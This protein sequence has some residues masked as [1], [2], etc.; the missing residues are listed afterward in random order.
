MTVLIPK[1]LLEKNGSVSFVYTAL[2][3][4]RPVYGVPYIT[5][6]KIVCKF[7]YGNCNNNNLIKVTTALKN[8][9]DD[10]LIIAKTF[11]NGFYEIDVT[12]FSIENKLF[13]AV[14]SD[15]IMKIIK[16]KSNNRFN[17]L[18]CFYTVISTLDVRTKCG[19]RCAIVGYM[20]IKYIASLLNQTRKTTIA[21][22][23]QL[24]E[25]EILY[26]NRESIGKSNIYGRYSD[27]D[28][29]KNYSLTINN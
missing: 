14:D 22:I 11:D 1:Q 20:P 16:L 3:L 29:I 17:L 18:N 24:E 6:P 5:H 26:V 19:N 15:E 25:L 4:E 28:Y 21:Y 23:K 27:M 7:L 8:L 9:I 13:L 12:S 2:Y 10:G